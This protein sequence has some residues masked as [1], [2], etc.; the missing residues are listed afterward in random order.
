MT[1]QA[2]ALRGG[3]QLRWGVVGAGEI[4]GFFVDALL[5]LTDQKVVAVGARDAASARAFADRYGIAVAGEY[6]DVFASPEVDVV[7]VATVNSTHHPLALAAIAAGKH[8]LVEKPFALDAEEAREI[9]AAARAR[10]VF[11]MEAMWTR[12]VPYARHIADLLDNDELGE[13]RLA[14]ASVGWRIPPDAPALRMRTPELGGGATLDHGVYSLWFVQFALGPLREVHALGSIADGVDVEFAASI[15]AD[16]GALGVAS[17]SMTATT[18]GLATIVGTRGHLQTLDHFVFPSRLSITREDKTEVWAD[19][20]GVMGR[21]GLVWQAVA[22]AQYLSEGLTESP[23]HSLDDT[24]ALATAMD[25]VRAD[26]RAASEGEGDHVIPGGVARLI[27]LAFE[28]AIEQI[29][30]GAA[31][32]AEARALYDRLSD[33]ERLGLLDGDLTFPQGIASMVR[34]GYNHT[35]YVAGAVDRLGIPGIR[36]SDGPR[37]IVMGRSTAFPVA[38]ARAATFDRAL[39]EEIGRAIGAEGRAQ[40]ANLFGGVCVNLLRHPGWGRAQESY[41]EDPIVLGEMGAAMTRG[42]RNELIACVKHFA[43]NSME[44]AR[45]RVDVTVDEQSLHEVYLPH[46]KRVIEEGAECVM[47]AYNSVNG[48]WAGDSPVLLTDILRDEWKFDGF[49]MS[50]FIWGHRDP[51]G[52]VAAGLDLEMPFQQQRANALPAALATGGLDA[53]D[54]RVAGERLIRTQLTWA[55]THSDTVPPMSVVASAEHAALARRAAAQSAVLL[56]NA[57]Y[58]ERPEAALPF[59]ESVTSIAVA[60]ALAAEP[61][62]GDSGSSKV[63]PPYTVSILEGLQKRPGVEIRHGRREE[64]T[65]LA[66]ESDAAVVVVGLGATDEGESMLATDKD[67]AKLTPGI[68][69]RLFTLLGKLPTLFGASPGGDRHDLRLKPEDVELVAA[70]AAVNPRTVVVVIAGSAVTV[71]EIRDLVPAIL[72][73]WYPGMEGGN[74]IADVLF[75]DAEPEGRLPFVIPTSA[76]HLPHWDPDAGHETYDRWWGYR[77]LDR[78]RHKPAFPFGFGL[79][80]STH[81]V[82]SVTA[83]VGPRAIVATVGLTNTGAMDSSTV[84]QIY[85]TRV[86]FAADEYARQL[87]GFAKVRTEAG[88]STSVEVVCSLAPLSHRD[89]STRA[90]HTAAGEYEIVAAQFAGDPDAVSTAIDIPRGVVEAMTPAAG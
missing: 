7:Y 32:G 22:L 31:A 11:A 15:R 21:D 75:G 77:K 47:S 76:D 41:G 43:L 67:A 6:A 40:G 80:Y 39:E 55:A 73:A 5:R 71:E 38:I 4:A 81:S 66:R 18:A 3:S 74:A 24:I 84:V 72:Y 19:P 44:N 56:R 57:P 86:G 89:P 37:G 36:F 48:Q 1:D 51:V 46:F 33:D 42:V 63:R 35:P 52:S 29:R 25:I 53:T 70:V 13:P 23:L 26:L 59:D 16:S 79:G 27:R 88:R 85:A 62:L 90:W 2:P 60:G 64:M 10:G 8:V 20:S 28:A 17:G 61:N 82:D 68:A 49:V 83:R 50:D 45:F 14:T 78:D 34:S 30:R 9:A 87:I 58:G 12:Y 69:G 54:V 65:R